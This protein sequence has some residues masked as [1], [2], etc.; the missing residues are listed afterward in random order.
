VDD[1]WWT[2]KSIAAASALVAVVAMGSSA[3]SATDVAVRLSLRPIDGA[4][5]EIFCSLVGWPE[6]DGTPGSIRP[7]HRLAVRPGGSSQPGQAS[8]AGAQVAA[9]PAGAKGVTSAGNRSAQLEMG[10]SDFEHLAPAQTRGGSAFRQLL[11]RMGTRERR[12]ANADPI[13]RNHRQDAR[14]LTRLLPGWKLIADQRESQP[15]AAS[16]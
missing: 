10:A 6:R 7:G 11:T 8:A 14:K 1:W 9:A 2:V 15:M 13:S 12:R 16:C 4:A 3:S 5:V